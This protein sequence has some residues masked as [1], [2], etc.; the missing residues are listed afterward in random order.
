MTDAIVLRG[1]TKSFA[2]PSGPVRAVRGIDLDIARGETV[3]LLG[4]NGAG[5]STT[6]EIVLGLADAD[7]GSV[8][9]LGG[10][11]S[12]A[13]QRGAVGAMLQVG[14]VLGELS[15]RELVDMMGAL[16]PSPLGVDE[17]LELAGIAD[18]ADRRT[19]RLSGGQTQRVRF[20]VA[21]VSNPDLVILDEPTVAMDVESRVAFWATMRTFTE[22]GTTVIFA[23]HYLEEADDHADRIVLMARG[24]VVADGTPAQLRAASGG[25]R[26]TGRLPGADAVALG[27]LPGV[28]SATVHH[29]S[30]ELVCTDSDVALRAVLAAHPDLTDIGVAGAGLEQAFLELTADGA[31]GGTGS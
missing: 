12:D 10:R 11:P 2:G 19:N 27:R 31:G 1:L 4:P 30:I 16:F 26:I 24:E 20:A 15:V 21:M 17:T 5:K 23:T 25:R 29:D 28:T 22:R 13:V 18:I 6:I 14:A 9:V 3:A 8:E 7:A